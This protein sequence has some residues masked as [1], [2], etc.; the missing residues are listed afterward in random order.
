M[1]GEPLN[2]TF[3]VHDLAT[4]KGKKNLMFKKYTHTFIIALGLCIAFKK[5]ARSVNIYVNVHSP[6]NSGYSGDE[7]RCLDHHIRLMN[8]E[9]SC[10]VLFAPDKW[11]SCLCL[12]CSDF[13]FHRLLGFHLQRQQN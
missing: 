9:N 6:L 12:A 7:H 5:H 4:K 1:S 3:D 2:P 8:L 13:R 11:D 10:S